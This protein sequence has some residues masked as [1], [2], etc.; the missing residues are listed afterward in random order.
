MPVY[1]ALGDPFQF[2]Q[3][4]HSGWAGYVAGGTPEWQALD[5]HLNELFLQGFRVEELVGNQWLAFQ[6]PTPISQANPQ[7]FR[8][9]RGANPRSSTY[10]YLLPTVLP[11]GVAM[12]GGLMSMVLSEFASH[13]VASA[14]FYEFF[15]IQTMY[16]EAQNW[17]TAHPACGLKHIYL[18]VA[19][20]PVPVN[21]VFV[22]P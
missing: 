22:H 4:R 5:T 14:S 21:Q 18:L 13:G 20:P 7:L 12:P 11:A 3:H 1:V 6:G 15:L 10:I 9:H 17:L 19:A 16:N 8:C 2:N